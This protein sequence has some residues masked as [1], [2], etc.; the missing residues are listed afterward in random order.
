MEII[1]VLS[2]RVY[3]NRELNLFGNLAIL[4][5]RYLVI[6]IPSRGKTVQNVAGPHGSAKHFFWRPSGEIKAL[7]PPKRH[8]SSLNTFVVDSE[9][10]ELNLKLRAIT[11]F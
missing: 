9:S 3:F 6:L 10:Q 4:C 1:S 5:D 2:Q 11:G 7:F 8:Y